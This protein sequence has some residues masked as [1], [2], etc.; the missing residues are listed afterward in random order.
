MVALLA[1]NPVLL[2][3]VTA[4]IGF[5]VGRV[6]VRGAS[7]G[8]A[9]VL[10]VGLVIGAQNPDLV[11]PE[12]ARTLGLAIFVYTIG[13]SSGASFFASFNR[14]GLRDNALV[15]LV[16]SFAALLVL[17]A[18]G[19]FDLKPTVAAGFF[20]GATTNT[21]A[22]AGVIEAVRGAGEA[23]EAAANE[24][25]VGYSIAYPMGVLGP[26]IAIALA[27]RLF[28]IDY[29]KEAG[30]LASLHLVQEEIA[31]ATARVTVPAAI[32]RSVRE[33]QRSLQVPVVLSRIQ[34]GTET[35]LA[36]GDV[37]LH[38]GD[39]VSV[40]GAP[41]HVEA[42]VAAIGER[43]PR[44]P[45][46]DRSR[47]D[48]RRIFVSRTDVVGRRLRDL[49]LPEDFDAIV[50]RV[51][52]GDVDVTATGDTVLELGD[53]VRVVAG[54]TRMKAVTDR[55]GDSYK[56]LSEIDLLTFGVGMSLGLLLGSIQV[57]L[58][59][60][61]TF[62]LGSAAGP[63]IVG[64]VLGALRRTGPIVW[65][66]PYSANLTLR[67]LG[68][69]LFLAAVGL[70]SGYTF[71]TMFAANSGVTLLLVGAVISIV[72]PM[73]T[74]LIGYRLLRIPFGQLTGM[75]SAQQ[76]QPAVLGYALEDSGDEAPNVGY[77]MVY[78][79]AMITKILLAQVLLL[80]LGGL[81]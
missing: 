71:R 11:I 9:A 81:G 18:A 52:R 21:P 22:L 74:L 61:L 64:L 27:R 40:V 32:G 10:F 75:V 35:M 77:A 53:R 43:D 4:A 63:L 41:A 59:G 49:R 72:V 12:F 3:F 8:V 46:L 57:P 24:P 50:T 56:H 45:E 51:R 19:I 1:E 58:P 16:L 80:V 29:R 14:K 38:E 25:T 66:I 78:P 33:L 67:Q 15:I 26:I 48:F 28:R 62:E 6:H 73:L 42:A 47:Y 76:T 34:R 79:V 44:H 70:G 37:R 31:S 54:R 36:E 55:L 17:L 23:G 20:A 2:L 7:L 13:L 69:M 5:A 30:R 68:L 65:N 39:L 60:G